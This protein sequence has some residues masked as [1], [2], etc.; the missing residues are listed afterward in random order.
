MLLDFK[1]SSFTLQKEENNM[2]ELY[3][4]LLLALSE[5]ADIENNESLKEEINN[6]NIIESLKESLQES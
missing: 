4:E 3:S 1:M 2:S 6:I 5:V